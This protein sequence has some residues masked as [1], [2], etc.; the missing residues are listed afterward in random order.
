MKQQI[1]IEPD[2]IHLLGVDILKA[3]IESDFDALS[4]ESTGFKFDLGFTNG[5][6]TEEKLVR[7]ELEIEVDKID[8]RNKIVA[9]SQFTLSFV[10]HI[11]NFDAF[12]QKG[13]NEN[14][15]FDSSMAATLGGIC[16]STARGILLTR[17]QGTVFKDFILPVID[18]RKLLEDKEG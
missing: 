18:P 11:E 14:I 12:I 4:I 7:C 15:V 1:K 6:N 13:N 17:F 16:F 10:F 3:R 5:F 8:E 2:K 9:E